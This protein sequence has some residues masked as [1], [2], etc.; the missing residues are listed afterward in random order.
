[1]VILFI[2]G[3][4]VYSGGTY[5]SVGS[6]EGARF[7]QKAPRGRR[8]HWGSLGSFKGRLWVAGFVGVGRFIRGGELGVVG[9]IPGRLVHLRGA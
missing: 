8:I 7:I 9:F 1:M 2:D 5:G 6:F 3:H 4:S